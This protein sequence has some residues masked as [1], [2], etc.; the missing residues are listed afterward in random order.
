[1]WASAR[2]GSGFQSQDCQVF[3]C[4]FYSALP[5]VVLELLTE[6]SVCLGESQELTL[7]SEEFWHWP[8][9]S[10]SSSSTLFP[11]CSQST[12]CIGHA[13]AWEALLR[14]GSRVYGWSLVQV[15]KDHIKCSAILTGFQST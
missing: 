7:H 5:V 12:G 10:S 3:L 4:L 2:P 13:C 15:F 14:G 6:A 1:M 9:W 8:G 11:D